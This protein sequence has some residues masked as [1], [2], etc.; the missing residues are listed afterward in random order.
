MSDSN[1]RSVDSIVIL[2]YEVCSSWWASW[3]WFESG[4]NIAASYF[5]WKVKRKYGRYVAM[6][7]AQMEIWIEQ[8]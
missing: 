7:K 6:K 1:F 5:A 8:S 3:I 4:Q 2:D